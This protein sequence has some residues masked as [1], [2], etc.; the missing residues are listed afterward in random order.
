PVLVAFTPTE[1]RFFNIVALDR[2]VLAFTVGISLLTGV[3]FGLAPA[4]YASGTGFSSAL[5]D[6]ERGSSSAHIRGRG[7][8]IG[9]EVAVSLVLLIGAGLML[10]SFVKLTHVDPGFDSGRLLV[11][12]IGYPPSAPPA[13][14]TA[15]Y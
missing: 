9:A 6:A 4:L 12:D 14:H 10:K 13:Q 3:I 15:F 7:L 2:S 8:L 1:L 5:H 11:F